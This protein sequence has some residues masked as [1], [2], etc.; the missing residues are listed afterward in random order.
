MRALMLRELGEP[1]N[2]ALEDV[3]AP[4]PGPGEVLVDIHTAAVNF[5]DLLTVQGKYQVRPD[6]PFVPGKEGAGVVAVIGDGVRRLKPGDRV[7]VQVEYGSFA[8]QAVAPEPD[9]YLMP[10]AIGFDDAAAIGIA[11]QTAH[12]AL[13]DRAGVQA[14][15]TVLVTGAS[16]SVGI[17]AMQLAKLFGCRVIAG[18]TTMAK[19]ADARE[20]G[21]DEV[22][23]LSGDNARDAVRDQ[24]MALTGGQGV[25]VVIEI[26]GGE[27]FA[28]ALRS[29]AFCGR[30][31]VVGF[32]SG[33]IPEMR[34]NYVLLKNIAVT[35]VD[36]GQYRAREP[37]WM[38]RV[39]DE[40]FGYCADGRVRLPIQAR[41][42]MDRFIDAFDIIRNRE[43]RGKVLLGIRD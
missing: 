21:A 11:F 42:P 16:G 20:N 37:D 6:L 23:D 2:L 31:V 14:G 28:G 17:A 35:G 10:D 38:R 29:L 5:P 33:E 8:E 24:V 27:V 36:R 1:E 9:C 32:T 39:Q 18:L 40:I 41:L 22:I 26:I 15:E 12:F 19:Q 4:V 13:V 25:D 3:P 34:V 30:L 7:M 43:V